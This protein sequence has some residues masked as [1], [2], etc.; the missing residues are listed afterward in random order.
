LPEPTVDWDVMTAIGVLGGWRRDDVT[1]W[2]AVDPGDGSPRLDW[3]VAAEDRWYR[4]AEE[5]SVR[6]RCVGGTP[7]VETRV[8]VPGGDLVHR[9]ACV[10]DHGGLTVVEVTNESPLPVAVALTRP[11][12]WLVR[13][14]TVVPTPGVELPA[15]SVVVPL[16]HRASV[17]AA[18]AHSVTPAGPL[19]AD[20]PSMDAVVRGWATSC[21]RAGR[22]ILPERPLVEGWVHS[23]TQAAL[24]FDDDPTTD[25]VDWLLRCHEAVRLGEPAQRWLPEVS[26]AVERALRPPRRLGRRRAEVGTEPLAWDLWSAVL[27]AE[28]VVRTGDDDR[29]TRDVEALRRRL[30]APGPLPGQAPTGARHAAWFEQRIVRPLPD[31]AVALFPDGL[32]P[33]WFGASLEAHEVEVGGG[34]RLSFALRWHGE[35]PALLWEWAG[36]PDAA[37]ERVLAGGGLDPGWSATTASGE[38]LLG[39]PPGAPLPSGSAEESTSFT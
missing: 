24:A 35:R 37:P 34:W 38:A 29:A 7:V 25:P 22:W 30:R 6:Q 4:P 18:L 39:I 20:L 1:T 31:G 28:A 17:R 26:G 10:P 19:P 27:A 12:L 5:P 23:R 13:P 14:P 11:D 9:V 2:G 21:E 33:A 32:P 8:R 16:G 15:G 36:G 3:W